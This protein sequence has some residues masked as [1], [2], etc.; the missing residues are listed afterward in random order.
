M[1]AQFKLLWVI[2]VPLTALA[3]ALYIGWSLSEKSRLD[4][5]SDEDSS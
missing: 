5:A 1:K 4:R 3:F 2:T